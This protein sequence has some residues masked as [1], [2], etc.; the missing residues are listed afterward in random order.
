MR[1]VRSFISP[2]ASGIS[3]TS[4]IVRL[5]RT[6]AVWS[7]PLSK[8]SLCTPAIRDGLVYA[9]DC[10]GTVHC[11]DAATGRACWTHEV[12]GEIWASPLA[13]DGRIYFLN[14]QGLTTV[15]AAAPRLSR[16]AANQLDDETMAS[17]IV[18][19]GHIFI[20]GR[21]TL[22]CLGKDWPAGL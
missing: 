22:Y 1:S 5:P 18:S 15:V 4:G 21:K 2:G 7:Y 8:H 20:R 14:T 9:T 17:P 11:I 13:A 19:D 16:L 3:S 12:K 6:A 10:G